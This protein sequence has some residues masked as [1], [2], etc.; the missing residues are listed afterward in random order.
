MKKVFVLGLL[1]IL[2]IG[3]DKT[4]TFFEKEVVEKEVQMPA[5]A[6]AFVG[7][8][9]SQDSRG[10]D[11]FISISMTTD[12]LLEIESQDQILTSYNKKS[13]TYGNHPTISVTNLPV[14]NGKVLLLNK[15]YSYSSSTHDLEEDKNG[16]NITGNRRTD[17]VM[18]KIAENH[19][20][21]TIE[22]YEGNVNSN[23]NKVVAKRIFD[24]K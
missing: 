22:I 19:L 16:A 10:A 23:V 4:E 9:Y 6:E 14:K 8:W 1:L 18:E 15:S 24:F 20:R 7:N 17:I 21:V 13:K 11:S 12:N 3:C 5:P 2:S